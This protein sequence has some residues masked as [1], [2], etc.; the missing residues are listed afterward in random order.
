[1]D[2]RFGEIRDK[3]IR[4][5]GTDEME[6]RGD[7][8]QTRRFG[9]FGRFGTDEITP[10]ICRGPRRIQVIRGSFVPN[11]PKNYPGK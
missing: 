10:N 5:F 3:E 11:L 2:W 4:R 8:G 6:I 7:S 9:R 1:M